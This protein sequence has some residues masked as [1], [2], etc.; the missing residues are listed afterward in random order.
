MS[1]QFL[2]NGMNGNTSLCFHPRISGTTIFQGRK[3]S[4]GK[5]PG[6]LNRTALGKVTTR[7][8]MKTAFAKSGQQGIEYAK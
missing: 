2:G 7:A 5:I 8:G 4:G 6:A 1:E 3:D